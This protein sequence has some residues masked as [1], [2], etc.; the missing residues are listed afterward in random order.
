MRADFRLWLQAAVG[1]SPPGL[2]LHPRKRT[3]PNRSLRPPDDNPDVVAMKRKIDQLR[4]HMRAGDYRSALALAATFHDLDEHDVAIRRAHEAWWQPLFLTWHEP[5][6]G[7]P[8]A[9]IASRSR[10]TPLRPLY[11]Q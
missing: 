10:A 5:C 8:I 3:L 4:R 1:R 7:R 9:R 6:T 2:P 11:P